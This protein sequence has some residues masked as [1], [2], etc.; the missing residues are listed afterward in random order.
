MRAA[1]EP[2]NLACVAALLAAGF[3]PAAG[4]EANHLPDGRIVPAR[5]FRHDTDQP[6]RC[7]TQRRRRRTPKQAGT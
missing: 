5:W 3:E 6:V 2:A 4:P 1:T 7:Q